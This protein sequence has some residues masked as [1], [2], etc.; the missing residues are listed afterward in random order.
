MLREVE[1]A[2]DRNG[3]G[4]TMCHRREHRTVCLER[5]HDRQRIGVRCGSVG[6]SLALERCAAPSVLQAW[7][8]AAELGLTLARHVIAPTP[9]RCV[10]RKKL[11]PDRKPIRLRRD[12]RV[13]SEVVEGPTAMTGTPLHRHIQPRGARTS[14]ARRRHWR[15]GPVH[16]RTPSE[17]CN[18]V[19]P[20]AG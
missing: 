2:D 6:S 19:R 9:K 14:P 1:S 8:S 3:A 5:Y 16:R 18:H 12:E 13:K 10:N 4:R 15:D 17:P 11:K 20:P 7:R